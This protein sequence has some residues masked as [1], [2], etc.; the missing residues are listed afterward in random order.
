MEDSEMRIII[1]GAEVKIS[2]KKFSIKNSAYTLKQ[3]WNEL[4]AELK[5][6]HH[7]HHQDQATKRFFS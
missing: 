2:D 1:G 6:E 3:A 4:I 7:P 5:A